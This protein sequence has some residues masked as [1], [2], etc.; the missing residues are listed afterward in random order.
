M[1][2]ARCHLGSAKVVDTSKFVCVLGEV[3]R[4]CNERSL[5]QWSSPA[6]FSLVSQSEAG[7][8]E[9]GHAL[10]ELSATLFAPGQQERASKEGGVETGGAGHFHPCHWPEV[11]HTAAPR[12]GV[13]LGA[14]SEPG[15]TW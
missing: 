12:H 14:S 15:L 10:G 13:G 5:F 9:L 4:L 2:V 11:S 3:M 6:T 7:R 1:T 8:Q